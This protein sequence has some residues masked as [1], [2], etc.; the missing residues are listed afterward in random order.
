MIGFQG[1][2]EQ[3][4]F[5]F[6][7]NRAYFD[8]IFVALKPDHFF[9][10]GLTNLGFFKLSEGHPKFT[11]NKKKLTTEINLNKIDTVIFYTQA[12]APFEL[13]DRVKLMHFVIKFCQSCDAKLIIKLR[14]LNVE[15]MMHKHKEMHSYDKILELF[16]YPAKIT[17]DTIYP[18]KDGQ[19]GVTFTSTIFFELLS[20]GMPVIALG[21]WSLSD[22]LTVCFKN[23]TSDC[24]LVLNYDEVNW[25]N[26]R[27]F[28]NDRWVERMLVDKTT[29]S[30]NIAEAIFE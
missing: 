17:V 8:N 13:K 18:D 27:L 30:K 3:N 7:S 20:K 11:F 5:S 10:R 1:G 16:D 23:S 21:D 26:K 2:V 22:P 29:F 28:L 9:L 14:S 4:L 12:I 25:T 6:I 19:I 15:N 24:G